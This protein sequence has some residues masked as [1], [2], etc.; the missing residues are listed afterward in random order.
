MSRVRAL[1]AAFVFDGERLHRDHAVVI[2]GGAIR[3][4]LPAVDLPRDLATESLPEQA[5]LAPGF[6]DVQVNGGG[7]VML[8][9]APTPE[10]MAAIAAAH[11]RFGTTSI[12][13]TLI[14]DAPEKMAQALSALG[15]AA[16]SSPGVIGFHLEGPF[17]SPKKPGVHDPAA[18]RRPEPSDIQ[19]LTAGHGAPVLVTLAPEVVLPGTIAAL[20]QAG[21]TVSIGHTDATYDE[22]RAALAE[23]ARG[24]THLFNAMRP[25][26]SRDPGP[27][28]A[29]LE[30]PGCFYGFIVDGLHVDPA[31]LRLALRGQGRPVL[32]TDAMA[33]VGGTRETFQLYGETITVTNGRCARADGTLAGAALDM[34]SAVRNAVAWLEIDLPTAL[35]MASV[36]PA[37]FVGLDDRLGRLA[38]GYRAD[39]VALD[40]ETVTALGTWVAGEGGF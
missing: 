34:A 19:L 30:T 16:R 28:A 31:I 24:F 4:V 40:P 39:L 6:I 25:L 26:G 35:R 36:E 32:V 18:I 1:K 37:A 8:N 29:A 14:T 5:W 11:R 20:V 7:D 3:A 2:E 9:D 38:P 21:V 12:L 10:A 15:E 23:G 27:I 17:I 33:P 13:P 22:T